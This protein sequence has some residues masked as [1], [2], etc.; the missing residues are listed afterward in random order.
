MDDTIIGSHSRVMDTVIGERCKLGDH[1][2]SNKITGLLDIEGIVIRSEFGAI[3]GDNVTSGPFT[4]YKNSIIGNNSIIE[5]KNSVISRIITD[6]SLV[7]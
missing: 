6:G 7:I 1:T 3:L 5:S 2:S 4:I